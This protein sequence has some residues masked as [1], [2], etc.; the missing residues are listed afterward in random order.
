MIDHYISKPIVYAGVDQEILRELRYSY[1]P[2][3]H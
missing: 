3:A 2:K 1:P